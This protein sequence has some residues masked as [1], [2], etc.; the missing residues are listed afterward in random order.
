M[1]RFELPPDA[2]SFWIPF[3]LL[4]LAFLSGVIA[5]LENLER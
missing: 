1:R 3:I 5:L 2:W 4:S